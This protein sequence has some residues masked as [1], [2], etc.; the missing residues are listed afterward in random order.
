MRSGLLAFCL[1]IL[2]VPAAEARNEKAPPPRVY[3]T[4]RVRVAPPVVDGRLDDEAWNQV[5]WSGDFVQRQPDETQPPS[6]QSEFKLLYDDDAVY[7]AFRCHDDPEQVSSILARHD[8]FPGDWIEVNIDSYHDYRTAFSFTLSLSG[9]RGDE[10]I[11]DDGNNWD[12]NWNPIWQ[13]ATSIDAQGWT[14]EMRIPL[15][16][17]RFDDAAEQVWGLQVQRRLYRRQ[18]RSTWQ[19]IPKDITGWVSNFGEIHGISGIEPGRRVEL[20]PYGVVKTERTAPEAG[21]PFRTGSDTD[22]DLGLDGKIGLTSDLTVDLTVNPDFGQVEADPSQVNLT[23]FETYFSEKRPFFIEGNDIFRLPLAPAITGGSFTNDWLF[24]SRRI[25][26]RPSYRPELADGEFADTPRYTTILG[27]LKL[28]GKTA[29]GTSV[30]VLESVTAREQAEI[31]GPGGERKVSVEPATNYLVGRVMQDFRQGN[32]VVGAMFTAVNR[33]IRDEHLQYLR[34]SAY[35]GGLDLQHYFLDRDYKLEVRAFGSHLRGAPEAIDLVQTSSARYYQRPDNGHV[36]YDSTRT[37]LSGLAGSVLLARTSNAGNLR[38]QTGVATRTPGFECNDIGYMRR[39]DEINQST[40]IGYTRRNPFAIFNNWNLNGNQ[41]LNWDWGGRFLG[42]SANVNTNFELKNRWWA[43][44][45]FTRNF[46]YVSNTAL[47]GGPSSKW[48]AYNNLNLEFGSDSTKPVQFYLG[49]WAQLGDGGYIDTQEIWAGLTLRPTNALQVSISPDYVHARQEMQYVDTADNA[50]QARYLF[51]SLD[52]ETFSLTFRV[53][54]SLTP[55]LTLQYYGAP[56]VSAGRYDTFKR[57]TDPHA[58]AYRDRFH[59]FTG[60]EIAY[61]AQGDT[62]AVDEDRSGTVDYTFDNPNFNFR[63]FNSNLVVRW[64]YSPGSTVY[65]VWSQ[66]RCNYVS[67]G[68]FDLGHDLETLFD[69]HPDNV[70]LIKIN[71]WFSL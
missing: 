3:R 11:S 34:R 4:E 48:P 43:Y 22:W 64:Q 15:S 44:A 10:Y 28:T 38:F 71:K 6:R 14:A 41:W 57:I 33:D 56:F 54:L 26:K 63:D 53:D 52:Q 55:D 16:Q 9:T 37:S 35:A 7:F 39:A 1:F 40:W 23:A 21:N 61:D 70:F 58:D 69:V 20:L 18:E 17:L 62:Y 31:A 32:T 50:G 60:Q 68:G 46:D 65:L 29:G 27:A 51:G 25:G 49:G 19:P 2:L 5:A 8:W 36:T 24:Y 12:G 30:G 47:R 59:A 45:S 67:N 66:T 13:G 42:A